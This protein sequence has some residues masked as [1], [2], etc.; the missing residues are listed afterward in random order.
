MPDTL[1]LRLAAVKA[2]RD[3]R[4]VTRHPVGATAGKRCLFRDTPSDE[5]L[6]LTGGTE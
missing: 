1:R 4:T 2:D 6:T 5:R 3:Q